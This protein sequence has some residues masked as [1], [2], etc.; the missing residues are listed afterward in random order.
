MELGGGALLV[1]E[2]AAEPAFA[3]GL[4]FFPPPKTTPGFVSEFP[5]LLYRHARS[6]VSSPK[7]QDVPG[8]GFVR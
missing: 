3:V 4:H 6:S 7:L 8:P 2:L 1:L 5:N